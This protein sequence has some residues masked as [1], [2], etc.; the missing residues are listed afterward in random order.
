MSRQYE[1]NGAPVRQS[2]ENR[3]AT[4]RCAVYTRKSTDE[5]L[6]QEFNSPTPSGNPQRRYLSTK[7]RQLGLRN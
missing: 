7:P 1:R 2:L 6:E 4:V 3:R 5:G